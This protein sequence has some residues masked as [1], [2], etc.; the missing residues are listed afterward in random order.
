MTYFA[1]PNDDVGGWSVGHKRNPDG[2]S[3]LSHACT[4]EEAK[5]IV[6]ALNAHFHPVTLTDDAVRK[7]LVDHDLSDE[8]LDYL[9]NH[10]AGDNGF[11]RPLIREIRRRRSQ[12]AETVLANVRTI[13]TRLIGTSNPSR[14]RPHFDHWQLVERSLL[15][16]LS[17]TLVIMGVEMPSEIA[18]LHFTDGRGQV[19]LVDAKVATEH[20]L[21]A[22]DRA[23]RTV[24]DKLLDAAQA[25]ITDLNQRLTMAYAALHNEQQLHDETKERLK[26]EV[27]KP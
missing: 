26:K 6:A 8:D 7:Y 27:A 9:M 13:V 5:V 4:K 19:S 11:V 18:A 1:K 23:G 17:D 14:V 10:V 16:E 25:T 24:A 22:V 3:Y 20:A 12:D 2:A 21:K 15:Q